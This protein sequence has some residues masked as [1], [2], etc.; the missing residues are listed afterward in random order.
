MRTSS[1]RTTVVISHPKT[2]GNLRKKLCASALDAQ[3][4]NFS[5]VGWNCEVHSPVL[6]GALY[7]H[8]H[9]K[10]IWYRN[11]TTARVTDTALLPQR[12]VNKTITQS[13]MVDYALII[14]PSQEM[15]DRNIRKMKEENSDT[16]N[17]TSAEY[18]RFTPIGI[19]IE[20]KSGLEEEDK[21]ILQL[22]TWVFAHFTRLEQLTKGAKMPV[23]PLLL[24]QG[25][26]WGFMLAER[27]KDKIL[28]L[29][30]LEIESTS[31]A[32]GIYQIWAA[33]R[34]LTRW[35]TEVYKPWFEKEVLEVQ[36]VQADT[37]CP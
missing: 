35:M 7:D 20:T 11:I 29:R 36:G 6:N 2:L 13:K 27:Q 3:N 32:V 15:E 12:A 23:L 8:R 19:S 5:E 26:S 9:S 21:A 28:I 25:H 17:H 10:G 4:N 30:N 1:C 24:V 16:I 14:E 34:R 18:A 31:S 37:S 33:I 22:G